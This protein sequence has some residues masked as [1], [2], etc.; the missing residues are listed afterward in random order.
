MKLKN[1]QKKQRKNNGKLS[2]FGDIPEEYKEQGIGFCE[3]VGETVGKTCLYAQDS[4]R[5]KDI[6]IIYIYMIIYFFI[7]I[8]INIYNL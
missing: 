7:Q 8:I 4:E 2:A 3:G 6:K 5:C 1:K